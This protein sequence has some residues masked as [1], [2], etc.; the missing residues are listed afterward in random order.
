MK[1]KEH[2]YVQEKPFDWI[3]GYQT[4]GKSLLWARRTQRW[5][6]LDVEG[7]ARD[8][9]AVDWP[10]R[11]PDLD[12]WYGYVERFVGISGN[13]D[14][15]PHLPDGDFLPPIV[16]NCME[17]H[18]KEAVERNF[19]DRHVISGRSAHITEARE[20]FAKQGRAT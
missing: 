17:E 9:F 20:I 4:G 10:I 5:S 11:Y 8:G 6:N 15:L 18:F 2:P 19:P 16:L 14:G 3:K 13:K 7:P 1:A 12:K